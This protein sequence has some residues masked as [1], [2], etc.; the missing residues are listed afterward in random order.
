M[1]IS[2]N[3]NSKWANP[4]NKNL[5]KLANIY[6]VT[7]SISFT[8]LILPLGYAI[9]LV[10][11][12]FPRIIPHRLLR[13]YIFTYGK[14]FCLLNR[15]V[16]KVQIN[17]KAVAKSVQPCIVVANHQSAMDLFLFG[18]Q[19]LDNFAYLVKS[20]PF[21][22]LFFFAPLM[23]AAGYVDVESQTPEKVEE[24]CLNLLQNG[25]SIIIFPEGKRSRDKKL[26]KFHIGAYLLACKANV[27]IVP[28]VFENSFDFFPP[29]SKTIY[30]QTIHMTGLEPI[31]P[32]NFTSFD[33]PHRQMMK[34]SYSQFN[35]FL[36]NN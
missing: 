2:K 32:K 24:Q 12:L 23:R 25:T 34:A 5:L 18:M 36:N 6:F 15:P 22:I 10:H 1:T 30:P 27:P 21:K 16:M 26:G 14:L 7:A 28:F 13:I 31:Y 4:K 9:L 8:A 33:L 35:K 29:G 19:S 11:K 20:W 17:N 3:C